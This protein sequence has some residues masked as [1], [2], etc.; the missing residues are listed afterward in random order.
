[1]KRAPTL[2][3]ARFFAE[4]RKARRKGDVYHHMR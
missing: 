2:F 3:G 1:M 4:T